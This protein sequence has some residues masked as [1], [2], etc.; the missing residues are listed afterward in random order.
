MSNYFEE[1]RNEL[2]NDYAKLD[3]LNATIQWQLLHD[4]HNINELNI[5]G[6]KLVKLTGKMAGKIQALKEYE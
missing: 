6:F 1:L 4:D 2:N 3:I 5:L